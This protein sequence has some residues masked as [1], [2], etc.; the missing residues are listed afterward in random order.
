MPR[1]RASTIYWHLSS[2]MQFS[3]T[4]VVWLHW[5]S[6]MQLPSGHLVRMVNGVI[7]RISTW[8]VKKPWFFKLGSQG[9]TEYSMV[10]SWL[11]EWPTSFG[12]DDRSTSRRVSGISPN[13]WH[14]NSQHQQPY[15]YIRHAYQKTKSSLKSRFW[16][17]GFVSMQSHVF[18]ETHHL[19]LQL[20]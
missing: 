18:E 15:V 10:G 4:S 16:C 12:I 1:T 2:G 11:L 8:F 20:H 14:R 17:H 9:R 13:R 19:G 7:G 6:E 5:R 3:H